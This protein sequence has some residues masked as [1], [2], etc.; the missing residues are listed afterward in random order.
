[1]HGLHHNPYQSKSGLGY[2][3]QGL[4]WELAVDPLINDG[5][6]I[7]NSDFFF[8]PFC[9]AGKERRNTIRW[10]QL[11]QALHCKCALVLLF[12]WLGQEGGRVLGPCTHAGRL[13]QWWRWAPDHHWLAVAGGSVLERRRRREWRCVQQQIWRS[14]FVRA[15]VLDGCVYSR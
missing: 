9:C 5:I 6:G 13:M 15:D 8:F 3:E 10:A 14:A 4:S 7:I 11:S 1:M 2:T 12:G